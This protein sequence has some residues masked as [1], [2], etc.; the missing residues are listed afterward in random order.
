M[1]TNGAQGG[2]EYTLDGA[3]NT[4]DERPGIGSRVSFAPPA[5]SVQE[6]KVT[7]SSFDAQ[8]G[9]TA[10]A[11]IDVAIKSGANRFS[12]T[13]YEFVRNDAFIANDFFYQSNRIAWTL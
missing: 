3:P 4:A 2:N 8:Q 7:T 1:T 10:G 6:F 12:G 9:R 11:S 13:V 5:D